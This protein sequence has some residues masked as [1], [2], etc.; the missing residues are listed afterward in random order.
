MKVVILTGGLGTRLAE[1]TSVRPKPMVEIGGRPILW[2]IMKTYSAH[3]F[4]EFVLC[5]GYKGYFIKEFFSNYFLHMS[6]VT[7][8][9][10]TRA[11]EVHRETAEPWRVT[12]VDTG[13]GTQTGGRLKRVLDHVAGEEVFALTYGDGLADVDFTAELAFH[14]AHGKLATVVA[15]RPA[16]RF[17]A[18]TLDNERVTAFAEKPV[19]EFGLD[20]WRILPAFAQG[21]RTDRGRLDYLGAWA[22]QR[23][24]RPRRVA[25]V[26]ARR[27]LAPDGYATRQN[28]SRGTVDLRPSEVE[29][30]VISSA[31]WLDQRVF[32]TGH[33]GFKGSWL[34]LML[35]RLNAR[36]TGYS[37]EPPSAPSLFDLAR[38]GEF[39]DDVRGD[40]RD[41]DHLREAM[42]AVAP[43]IVIHM[44]A[45]PL[46]RAAYADP[47][48]TYAT[49]VMGTVNVLEAARATP[50]VGAVLVVTT[51]KCYENK[52]WVWGYRET[53]ALGGH[54][55]YSNSKACAEL[56]ASAYRDSFFSNGHGAKILTARAGNVIGGGDFAAD[57]IVPDAFR[58]FLADRPLHIRN[59]AAVRPWQHVLEPL[60]GYLMLIEAALTGAV[61]AD[62]G[63]NFGPGAGAEQSVETLVTRF[64]ETYGGDASWSRDHGDHP[65][66]AHLLRLDTTKAREALRWSPLLDFGQTVDWT[67]QW[68]RD[69][70]DGR[71]IV[72]TTMAQIDQYLGQR[73][74]LVSP[75]TREMSRENLEAE[76][77]Y[78]GG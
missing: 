46:V 6:D 66:E 24:C 64:I 10:R 22:A 77:R 68:Y 48:S 7:F 49:N 70:A 8:D 12:L 11:M 34:S 13:D 3:G 43:R 44:A 59:P 52:D 65:H 51:D 36:A 69:L 45:Q 2:H 62:G 75:F 57:R 39:I 21:R 26:R 23:A 5:L 72:E 40:I 29:N 47:V 19:A 60:T 32:V 31:F 28:L 74:R 55:P 78:R 33:T 76:R 15:A 38:V 54:D 56:V 63:W 1:E 20:Q 14:K 9:M 53:D 50:S 61:R 18:M 71:D 67:T 37:L 42:T 58:A 17:G 30:L 41:L 27:I 25:G 73:V 4:N 35:S 16:M